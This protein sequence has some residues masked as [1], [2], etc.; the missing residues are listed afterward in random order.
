MRDEGRYYQV[1][2]FNRRFL[3]QMMLKFAG[4]RFFAVVY[5]QGRKSGH[6]YRSPVIALPTNDGFLIPLTYGSDTDWCRN[7]RTAGEFTLKWQR[8]MHRLGAPELVDLSTVSSVLPSW[9]W[10]AM[11]LSRTKQGLQAKHVP[12]EKE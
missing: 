10:L 5:H 9:M 12:L 2:K 1:R 3:N 7:A 4:G 11:R 6:E 8:E